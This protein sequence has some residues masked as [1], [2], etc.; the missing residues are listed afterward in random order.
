[1]IKFFRKIRQ[2]FL[3]DGKIGKYLQYAIGELM[4]V[5]I[6][7]LIALQLNNLNE[8]KKVDNVRQG[9]YNQLLE[10]I[11]T[12]IKYVGEISSIIDSNLAKYKTY[13]EAFKKPDLPIDK[14]RSNL[15]KLN[16]IHHDLQFQTNTIT[17]LQNT[18][19]IKIIPPIL[20]E[21]LIGL[22]KYQEQ[23]ENSSHHNNIMSL[24][25]MNQARRYFGSTN[26]GRNIR[27]QPK[28]MEWTLDENRQVEL[29]IALEG[30]MSQKVLSEN[31]SLRAFEIILSEIDE[32]TRLI[33]EELEK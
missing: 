13:E 10:D 23:A 16:W 11:E 21:K 7:I 14:I 17:T 15:R 26:F 29:I 19:D 12:D 30:S 33:N 25:L 27:N 8:D 6:G 28:L 4:L 2:N 18:G 5:V 24:E 20:R 22:R 32:V 9:Y 31:M 3:N 1:M